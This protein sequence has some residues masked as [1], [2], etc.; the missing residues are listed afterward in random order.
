MEP[1]LPST[2]V[3]LARLALRAVEGGPLAAL[4]ARTASCAPLFA[5]GTRGYA[6]AAPLPP[7]AGGGGGDDGLAERRNSNARAGP[8]GTHPSSPRGMQTQAQRR[9]ATYGGGGSSSGSM[10]LAWLQP[11]HRNADPPLV[12]APP[13]PPQ[14]QQQPPSQQQDHSPSEQARL[15]QLAHA[16]HEAAARAR[17]T[18]LRVAPPPAAPA[19]RALCTALRLDA[20]TAAGL[21]DAA[22]RTGRQLALA[23]ERWLSAGEAAGLVA[24]LRRSAELDDAAIALA[25]T[26][27]P[28][29][30][31]GPGKAGADA[32][33]ALDT[34]TQHAF[35]RDVEAEAGAARGAVA[36]AA[37]AAAAQGAVAASALVAPAASAAAAAAPASQLAALLRKAPH[38]LRVPPATLASNLKQLTEALQ[39][40]PADAR[41]ALLAHPPLLTAKPGALGITMG[42][43]VGLGASAA[44]VRSMLLADPRWATMPLRDLSI[45]WQLWRQELKV[46]GRGGAK[47]GNG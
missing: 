40:A 35:G 34:L 30:L 42:F 17:D 18:A 45:F 27:C 15:R 47:G 46:G 19:L 14:P 37:A 41:R 31:R 3:A 38:L 22:S 9:Q 28:S 24:A 29:L 13:Q 7:L 11:Q 2:S 20:D 4:A 6:A 16:T 26:R 10:Q 39:L 44:D 23:K 36:A 32:L 21:A 43:L 33:T 8:S 12:W 25:L 1:L 5:L